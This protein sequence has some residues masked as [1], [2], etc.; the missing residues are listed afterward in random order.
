ML[1]KM[2]KRRLVFIDLTSKQELHFL[3]LSPLTEPPSRWGIMSGRGTPGFSI[4]GGYCKFRG[5]FQIQRGT[6]PDR[7]FIRNFRIY[8]ETTLLEEIFGFLDDGFLDDGFQWILT[9]PPVNT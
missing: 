6:L 3:K 8:M 7:I 9:E 1:S 4:S 2:R 5:V